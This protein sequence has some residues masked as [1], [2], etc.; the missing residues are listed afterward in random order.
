MSSAMDV[1]LLDA[2][3][4][5]EA[6][7]H[8][9]AFD[10][11]PSFWNELVNKAGDG[12]ILSIDKVQAELND[13]DDNL[14]EW[15]NDNFTQ[16]FEPTYTEDILREYERVMKWIEASDFKEKA[17]KDF[18]NKADAWVVACAMAREYTVITHE[19]FRP[20][21]KRSVSHPKCL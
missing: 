16:W 12:R 6:A 3:V 1:Y 5:I 15:A 9:Y 2:N 20:G 14:K 18:T 10:I 11:V 8:Y 19:Q 4:F 13:K 17:K 21:I 7:K